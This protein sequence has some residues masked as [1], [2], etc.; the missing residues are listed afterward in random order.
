[1]KMFDRNLMLI[2]FNKKIEYLQYYNT[3]F[4]V[5]GDTFVD[6][7]IGVMR[8]SGD[9]VNIECDAPE[10]GDLEFKFEKIV[11]SVKGSETPIIVYPKEGQKKWKYV[12]TEDCDCKRKK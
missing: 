12:C 2:Y 9:T 11:F 6:I 7:G 10:I 1:M 4:K 8:I 3:P 5:D